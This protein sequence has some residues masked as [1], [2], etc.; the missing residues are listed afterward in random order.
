[1]KS[2]YQ[3]G[4]GAQRL[5]ARDW[6]DQTDKPADASSPLQAE[7]RLL[8]LSRKLGP[9]AATDFS[10]I[11]AENFAYRKHILFVWR[12]RGKI[13]RK[14]LAATCELLHVLA[15]QKPADSTSSTVFNNRY[16]NPQSCNTQIET[17]CSLCHDD[18]TVRLV[19]NMT[20]KN[21][22]LACTFAIRNVALYAILKFALYSRYP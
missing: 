15:Q 9:L 6:P 16:Q 7:A 20:T 14:P 3:G 4:A 17:N 10:S 5:V 18:C 22:I 8:I 12:E 13:L 1:M 21:P 19:K 2:M 11:T